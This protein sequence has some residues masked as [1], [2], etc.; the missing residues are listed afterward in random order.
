MQ[1]S[2]ELKQ[3]SNFESFYFFVGKN[4]DF[5]NVGWMSEQNIKEGE[6]EVIKMFKFLLKVN[7]LIN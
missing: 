6:R 7:I 1:I 4:N 2:S 5:K 3:N